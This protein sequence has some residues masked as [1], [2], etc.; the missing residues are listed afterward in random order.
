MHQ[1]NAVKVTLGFGRLSKC[2]TSISLSSTTCNKPY[3]I[4]VVTRDKIKIRILE[5]IGSITSLRCIQVP[6]KHL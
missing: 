2:L 5:H 1:Y 6:I 3:N 4:T